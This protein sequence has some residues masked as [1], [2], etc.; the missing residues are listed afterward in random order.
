MF[1]ENSFCYNVSNAGSETIA[2]ESRL[3]RSL[4]RYVFWYHNL[5]LL[6]NSVKILFL[7]YVMLHAGQLWGSLAA[8]GITSQNNGYHHHSACC[9]CMAHVCW[10]DRLSLHVCMCFVVQLNCFKCLSI[11][12]Y[13][14]LGF[15]SNSFFC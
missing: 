13:F 10:Q 9:Q 5:V 15:I 14:S 6:N 12:K 3:C 7:W 4:L 8:S 11:P 1:W 2:Y